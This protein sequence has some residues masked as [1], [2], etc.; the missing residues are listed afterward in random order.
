MGTVKSKHL[1]LVAFPIKKKNN[2]KNPMINAMLIKNSK[3]NHV[4][5]IFLE[6]QRPQQITIIIEP[7]S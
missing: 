2:R 3:Q 7:L 1:R 4:L 6:S 5:T